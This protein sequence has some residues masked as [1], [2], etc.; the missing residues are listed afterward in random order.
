MPELKTLQLVSGI[1]SSTTATS[2]DVA[3]RLQSLDLSY[4]ASRTLSPEFFETLFRRA[5]TS[6]LR[7]KF[8][9]RFF[10]R[11]PLRAIALPL[12]QANVKHLD[13]ITMMGTASY[14]YE[15]FTSVTHLTLATDYVCD[16]LP[17]F[18]SLPA[19]THLT[20]KTPYPS[21]LT[22]VSLSTWQS[23]QRLDEIRFVNQDGM[24]A[25][26]QEVVTKIGL[27]HVSIVF[28]HAQSTRIA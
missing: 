17:F 23:L 9:D 7:L 1:P 22:L 24:D 13:I 8:T 12:V 3:F 27:A 4:H 20:L 16:H 19:L 18:N 15:D 2:T 14:N 21:D 6:L 10:N 11:H 5:S 28:G 25:D 26:L